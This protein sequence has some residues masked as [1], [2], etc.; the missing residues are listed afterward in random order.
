MTIKDID[1]I[2]AI[3]I[4][5]EDAVVLMINDDMPWDD[6]EHL[7]LMEEKLITYVSFAVDGR[8]LEQYPDAEGKKIK[9]HIECHYAPNEEAQS[10]LTVSA[11]LAQD[12]G[13][14]LTYGVLQ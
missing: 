1:S 5:N 7:P 4:D 11:K 12:A 13:I 14:T 10:F 3:G 8:L 2:D 6:E 9:I